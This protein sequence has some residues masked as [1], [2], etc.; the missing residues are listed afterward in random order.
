L[1]YVKAFS[2]FTETFCP[3]KL[4]Q[5]FIKHL[6]HLSPPTSFAMTNQLSLSTLLD[7]P[8]AKSF[9]ST[10]NRTTATTERHKKS[11]RPQEWSSPH[12]LHCRSKCH[13]KLWTICWMD[14]L[15]HRQQM[16]IKIS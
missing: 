15:V 6:Q 1:N 8:I 12:H 16:F 2:S 11:N 5:L 4:L 7:T 9:S 10:S 13:S 14:M 3:Q